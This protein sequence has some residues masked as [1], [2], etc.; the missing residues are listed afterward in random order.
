MKLGIAQKLALG[1][2]IPLILVLSGIG[3]LLGIQISGTVEQMMTENLTAQA[4]SGAQQV[5][6]FLKQYYGIV[7]TMI[8]SPAISNL[9]ADQ[10]KTSLDGSAYFS[11]M[12]NELKEIQQRYQGTVLG[13]WFADIGLQELVYSDNSR[14]TSADMDFST[15]EWYIRSQQEQKAIVT[16]AYIDVATQKLVIS[17]AGP[18][19]SN[20]RMI[21]VVGLDVSTEQLSNSLSSIQVGETGYITLI[22]SSNMIIY[23]PDSSVVGTTIEEAQYSDNM[24]QALLN[25]NSVKG[26][27]YTRQNTSYYGSTATLDDIDYEVLGVLPSEEYNSHVSSTV[28]VIVISFVICAI[29]LAIIV[30]LLAIS[31][32]RPL[33]RLGKVADRLADGE[34]DVDY[35]VKGHDEVARLGQSTLRIVERLKTYIKYIDELSSVLDQMG[36]GNL[37]FELQ[38]D[39]HG[40][41]AKLKEALLRIQKNLSETLSSI[42]MSAAQ[43]HMGSD[44]IA[45]GAQALAQGATEQASSVQELSSTVQSLNEKVTEGAAQAGQMIEQL[46]EVKAQVSTSNGQMQDMLTAMQDISRHSNAIGKII[47]TI[48]DIAF[49]TNILALN[50]AV[51]AARAGAAGKGFAVVADEV[52]NLAGKSAAAAKETN[53]LIAHSVEAVKQGESI[54]RATADALSTA[55]SNSDEVVAA[56]ERVTRDYQDQA[57]RLKEVSIGVNQISEVVQTNSATAEQSAA[58]SEQLSGQAQMLKGMI[59]HFVLLES[60]NGLPMSSFGENS[61][62]DSVSPAPV[63]H[64]DST[65]YTDKY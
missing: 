1:I 32:I 20:N 3:V 6:A 63:E 45:S 29:L 13:V 53:E 30:T 23:H 60:E 62:T 34:L 55:A 39:Y 65:N 59:S 24:K 49:Q 5:N 8:C 26:L 56:V 21:G 18:I 19:M 47:K 48:D 28:R 41:F 36:R 22:D 37:V 40:E 15:R 33:K 9:A 50:A 4:E 17:I 61:S 12:L 46:N 10:A 43:V 64:Y 58:A 38:Y 42:A 31:I 57:V 16:G 54:A 27:S 11:G 25:R 14:F 2:L 51:E 7:D 35:Q 52:R 44:Q